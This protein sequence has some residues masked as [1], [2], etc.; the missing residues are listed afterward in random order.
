MTPTAGHEWLSF[1]AVEAL[2]TRNES[3]PRVCYLFGAMELSADFVGW[4]F[5]YLTRFEK[6]D[7]LYSK[8]QRLQWNVEQ[9]IDWSTPVDPSTEILGPYALTGLLNLPIV[10][11]LSR[12]QREELNFQLTSFALSQLLHGEQAGLMGCGKFI[13]AA[14]D[15]K[16]KVYGA[17]Q[18]ADEARH[19][20]V[21]R[22][23]VQKCGGVQPVIEPM[24]RFF[25][26]VV[27]ENWVNIL[28][29]VQMIS[30]GFALAN[31][32]N[33]RSGTREP[34]LRSIL[35]YV[36]RDEARHVAFGHLYVR[37]AIAQLHPDDREAV[38]ENAFRRTVE[39]RDWFG[40]KAFLDVEPAFAAVGLSIDDV[41]VEFAR[42][43]KSALST[44]TELAGNPIDAMADIVFPALDRVG[45]V[46]PRTRAMFAQAR[47]VLAGRSTD[48][49]KTPL[50]KLEMD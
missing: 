24:K 12:S 3:R 38:A 30:E 33:Y 26:E 34:L 16:A 48:L 45:A 17:S 46:T 49:A 40:P 20:E 15:Y 23:Y 11:K 50:S 7:S 10:S 35:E 29:M 36:I 32:H 21:F 14:P 19:V 13:V 43:R 47:S 1:G 44:S 8:G 4:D 22:R 9:D 39:A 42:A 28:I 37:Q 18:A 5:E 27:K 25:G 41:A 31:L 6:L 2:D